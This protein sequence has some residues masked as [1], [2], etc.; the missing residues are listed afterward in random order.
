MHKLPRTSVKAVGASQGPGPNT[1]VYAYF[2]KVGLD[3]EATRA[4]M[5]EAL[6]RRLAEAQ[7]LRAAAE[8]E[9]RRTAD[10][11]TRIRHDYKDG[12]LSAA[13]WR[14]FGTSSPRSVRPPAPRP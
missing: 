12:H 2:E 13:E 4:Q 5:S 1:A 3:V 11:L 9:E 8:A 14:D 10:A 6:E 7:A